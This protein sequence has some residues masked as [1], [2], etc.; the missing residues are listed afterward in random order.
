MTGA[1]HDAWLEQRRRLSNTFSL[2]K[3]S[4]LLGRWVDTAAL[5]NAALGTSM[6]KVNFFIAQLKLLLQ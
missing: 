1:C 4:H 3:K 5:A 2:I 6:L